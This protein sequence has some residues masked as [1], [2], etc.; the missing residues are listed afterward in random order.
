LF[1]CVVLVLD[2]PAAPPGGAQ[3][4]PPLQMAPIQRVS[5]S[6]SS[7]STTS[8]PLHDLEGYPK[9]ADYMGRYNEVA[10]FRRFRTLNMLN[11]L[12]LQAELVELEV[13]YRQACSADDGDL[14][15]ADTRDLTKSFLAL[16]G[17]RESGDAAQLD[18]LEDI[19]KKLKE[20]SE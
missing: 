9:L 16:R 7:P 20:Y 18:Y 10:I 2:G 5:V 4:Q 6:T 11:I 8:I 1:G 15:N 3:A 13:K 14:E 12:S 17:T 19:R